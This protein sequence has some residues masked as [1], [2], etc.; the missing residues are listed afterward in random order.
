M[1]YVISKLHGNAHKDTFRFLINLCSL[2]GEA[3][4]VSETETE[5]VGSWELS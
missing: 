2:T 4:R 5:A 3:V 1:I